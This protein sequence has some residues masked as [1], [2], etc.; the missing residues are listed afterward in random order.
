M[1]APDLDDPVPSPCVSVCKL[2]M[3]TRLCLGCRRHIDEIRL[4]T[5]MTAAEKRAV[6]A[7][8][9]ERAAADP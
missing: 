8:L 7:R 3:A 6:W 5:K 9:E 4:W 2:D 1:A